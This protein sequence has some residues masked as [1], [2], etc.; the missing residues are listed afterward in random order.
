MN[1]KKRIAVCMFLAS[2]VMLHKPGVYT[3]WASPR[4]AL[5]A[6]AEGSTATPLIWGASEPR[7]P[8]ANR[9]CW[10]PWL[11]SYMGGNTRPIFRMLR[12]AERMYPVRGGL[13]KVMQVVW[14]ESRFNPFA[15]SE[16]GRHF[17]L[18]QHDRKFWMTRWSAWSLDGMP[19]NPTNAWTNI[20]VSMRIINAYGWGAWSCA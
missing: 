14:C 12:C 15:V 5:R 20:M 17:G 4:P 8:G 7:R 16:S 2:T 3:A 9:P 10:E 18:F 6:A 11:S 1:R 13:N 19:R